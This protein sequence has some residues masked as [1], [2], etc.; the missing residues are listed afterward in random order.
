[1]TECCLKIEFGVVEWCQEDVETKVDK[2]EDKVGLEV[3]GED[4][5]R[6]VGGDGS[7]C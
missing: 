5:I 2:G 7:G 4:E 6:S 3:E 1:M